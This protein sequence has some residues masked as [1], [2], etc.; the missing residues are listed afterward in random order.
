MPIMKE[1]QTEA[2]LLKGVG[3]RAAETLAVKGIHTLEDL[4]YYLPFRYEDRINPRTIEQ[5]PWSLS[6]STTVPLS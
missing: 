6:G 3:P 1:L 4:L 2:K 5:L